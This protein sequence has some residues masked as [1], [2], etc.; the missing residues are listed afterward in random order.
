MKIIERQNAYKVE[1]IDLENDEDCIALGEIIADK[2]VVYVQQ[3][4]SEQRLH[5]IH[6]LW[7]QPSLSLLHQYVAKRYLTGKHWRSLFV[8]LA[9]VSRAVEHI[10]KHDGMARVSFE[11]VKGKPTG[12]LSNGTLDWH[13]D[14]PPVIDNQI[15]VGLLSLWG[16]RHTQTTFLCTADAY[17]RL[18]AEDKSIV[19]EL[20]TVW[21]WDGC[22]SSKELI[23]EQK[24][25][26][27][28]NGFP[29]PDMESSLV[30]QTATGK[31]GFFFP[32][33]SFTKFRGMSVKDSQRYRDYLWDKINKPEYIYTH[34]WRDGEV[35]FMDQS[36]TLH[37]RPSSEMDSDNRTLCR[38]VSGLDKLFPEQAPRDNVL[39]QGKTYSHENFANMIDKHRRQE[40]YGTAKQNEK[41]VGA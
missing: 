36:I 34:D 30:T 37:A 31:R 17:D 3:N 6:S 20:T 28:Y 39:Y 12:L 35:M 7:G 14:R 41:M 10:A 5:D 29:L 13:S 15:V 18:N 8:N 33:H 19:D 38:M 2:C 4:I 32:T 26:L 23:A 27:R 25:I 40:F 21:N 9:R 1:D 22:T 24:E 16:T 11:K